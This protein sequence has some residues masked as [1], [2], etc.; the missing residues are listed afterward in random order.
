M[1]IKRPTAQIRLSPVRLRRSE[2]GKRVPQMKPILELSKAARVILRITVSFVSLG[3]AGI[4]SAEGLALSAKE[5]PI[6]TPQHTLVIGMTIS[7]DC[8]HVAYAT[9]SLGEMLVVVDGVEGKRYEAVGRISFSPVGNRIVYWARLSGTDLIVVDGVP[10]NGRSPTFSPD[11]NRLAF[12]GDS[13][14]PAIT[15]KGIECVR[16]ADVESDLLT[17]S[18]DGKRVAYM[19]KSGNK[20][21]IRVNGVAG[22]EYSNVLYPIFSPDSKH[23]AYEAK[24]GERWGLVVDGAEIANDIQTRIRFNENTVFSPDSRRIVFEAIRDDKHVVVIDGVEGIG[25]RWVGN[26]IFSPDSQRIAYVG[27]NSEW[28]ADEPE[29]RVVVDGAQG[30]EYPVVSKLVFSPD[31]KHV[32]YRVHL[33]SSHTGAKELIVVDGVERSIYDEVGEPVFSSDG[34]HVAYVAKRSSERFVEL[35]G[36]EGSRYREVDNLTFS[37]DGKH[38]AYI[39]TREDRKFV[40]VDGVEGKA[41]DSISTLVFESPTQFFALA[42]D[43]NKFLRLDVAIKL[44]S[45]GS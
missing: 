29:A 45:A 5:Q 33:G 31:S 27:T 8:R 2:S 21:T 9:G 17:F 38:I 10:M 3:A 28:G 42:R 1:N 26:L 32:G 25:F 34:K 12:V 35:D 19:S 41:Y 4:A 23:V 18:P 20:K 36:V 6:P 11:G 30:K 14:G 39:A 43:G 40:V 44:S 15:A 7:P 22:K 16:F 37:P 24:I 13:D